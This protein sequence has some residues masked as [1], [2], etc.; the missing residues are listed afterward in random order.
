MLDYPVPLKNILKSSFLNEIIKQKQITMTAIYFIELK[1][2]KKLYKTDTF[3]SKTENLYHAKLHDDSEHDQK[4]FFESLTSG[5]KPWKTDELND[6]EY[7]AAVALENAN[8]KADK[9][10]LD[11]RKAKN[12]D[13]IEKYIKPLNQ[14]ILCLI[15]KRKIFHLK[16]IN[17]IA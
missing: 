17:L 15:T 6:E 3:W 14:P 8:Y 11:V 9:A 4:R 16:K 12:Q 5:F 10:N 7:N 2:G 1:D 13:D